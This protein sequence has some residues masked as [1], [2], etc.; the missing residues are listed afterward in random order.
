[1]Q[2]K[3]SLNMADDIMTECMF[4]VGSCVSII[5]CFNETIEGEVIA[6]D[7]N[8][9]LLILSKSIFTLIHHLFYYLIV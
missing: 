5:T 3:T 1:M 4:T 7:Y 2:L 8:K 6:F 9:K